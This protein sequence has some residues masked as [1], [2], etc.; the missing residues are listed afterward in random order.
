[1][2]K[3]YG[4]PTYTIVWHASNLGQPEHFMYLLYDHA[5]MQLNISQE[6]GDALRIQ[7]DTRIFDAEY[8]SST[9]YAD[10]LELTRASLRPWDGYGMYR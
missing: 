9:E 5:L 7:P 3:K 6:G 8:F 10:Y 4:E 2:I 1:M